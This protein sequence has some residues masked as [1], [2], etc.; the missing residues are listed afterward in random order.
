MNQSEFIRILKEQLQD[1][2][3]EHQLTEIINDYESFFVSGREE[4]RTD[5]QIAEELGSPIILATS[6]LEQQNESKPKIANPG[7]R[8]CAFL[9]DSLIAVLPASIA[10]LFI[11]G[12]AAPILLLILSYSSPALGVLIYAG[13]G[14]YYTE[15]TTTVVYD[16]HTVKH[17]TYDSNKP[18]TLIVTTSYAV[19]FFYL[20]YALI[21]TWL[22]NGQTLGKKLLRIHVRAATAVP[23][24]RTTLF[25][26]EFL[27][28]VLI[29]SIPFV[30]LVSL[31]TVLFTKENKS[32]HDLLAGT[33]VT[34]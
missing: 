16:D 26:R 21:C 15:Q 22:M 6:L 29:N 19:I 11:G 33:I 28:K 20:F 13:T 12:L 9:I 4:G 17:T 1:R 30:P 25:I 7:K 18:S 23:A 8:L 10:S 31:F 27:G 34:E 5:N 14:A 32:L 24:T 3:S 2:M